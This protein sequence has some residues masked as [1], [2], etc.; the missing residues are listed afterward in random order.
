MPSPGPEPAVA[1]AKPTP[2]EVMSWRNVWPSPSPATLPMNATG[3][4]RLAMPAA[5]SR[6]RQQARS[7]ISRSMP[8][9]GRTASTSPSTTMRH[10]W[11]LPR[12]RNSRVRRN[13]S[14]TAHW[15]IPHDPS[16]P[17]RRGPTR[18]AS[19]IGRRR[20]PRPSHRRRR[21]TTRSS[22]SRAR[23]PMRR[24]SAAPRGTGR[25]DSWQSARAR[26]RGACWLRAPADRLRCYSPTARR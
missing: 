17:C 23:C 19:K 13:S 26:S 22:R 25:S 21:C 5:V 1:V 9:T 24:R 14:S 11:T 4:P 20:D 18:R 16:G 6:A 8:H 2:E 3:A 15:R 10:A 12:S 7:S